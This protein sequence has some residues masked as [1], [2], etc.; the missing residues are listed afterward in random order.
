MSAAAT[1]KTTGKNASFYR[2]ENGELTIRKAGVEMKIRSWDPPEARQRVDG[3]AHWTS[4]HPDFQLIRPYRRSPRKGGLTSAEKESGQMTFDFFQE[5]NSVHHPRPAASKSPTQASLRK[6]ALDA[7]RF[8]LPREVGN[9]LT[10]FRYRQW[11][12]LLLLYHDSGALDLA[13]SNPVL[14]FLLA[15]KMAG[16]ATL[17]RGLQCSSMRQ[18]EILDLLDLPSTNAAVKLIGKIQPESITADSLSLLGPVLRSELQKNKSPLSHLPKINTGV[19]EIV[20]DPVAVEAAS[21]KLLEEVASEHREKYRGRAVHMITSTLEMQEELQT[22]D[23]VSSFSSLNRLCEVH[24]RVSSQFRRRMRQLYKAETATKSGAFPPPPLPG[25]EDK[26][27]ALTSP[28]ELVDEGEEQ[29]NCVASYAPKVVSG[30]LYIYRVLEPERSTLS[31]VKSQDGSWK[32]G[33]L[34]GK[35]NTPASGKTERFVESWLRRS[36]SAMLI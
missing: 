16:D 18:R 33:E 14:S 22:G 30:E 12:L 35:F 7:F 29:G 11:L 1:A 21:P 20:T 31:L 10:P 15:Q 26:I 25:W 13:Q 32:V 36:E 6:K 8:S 9:A 27:E 24:S 5:T 23:K 2:F 28:K 4:F 17:I 34:E 19:L 3:T